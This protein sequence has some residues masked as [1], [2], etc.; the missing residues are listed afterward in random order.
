MS[1]NIQ[2]IRRTCSRWIP[3][4]SVSYLHDYRLCKYADYTVAADKYGDIGAAEVIIGNEK[5]LLLSVYINPNTSLENTEFLI[6]R[7]LLTYCPNACKISSI[8]EMKG[9][10]DIPIILT[11]DFNLGVSKRDNKKVLEFISNDFG[12]HLSSDK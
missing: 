5:C 2:T 1:T 10:N 4:L 7:S 6:S 12:L 8:L 11:G 9:C 3:L